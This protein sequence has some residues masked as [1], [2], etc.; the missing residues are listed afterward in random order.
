[1]LLRLLTILRD[2]HPEPAVQFEDQTV[3]LRGSGLESMLSVIAG[4]ADALDGV[5]RWVDSSPNR[6]RVDLAAATYL[7][8]IPR[9]PKII[10]I[11]LNYR[12]HAEES[13]LAIPD[14]PTVFCK[15][16][17]AATGHGH[18]VILPKNSTKPD[19]EAEFAVVIGSGGRHIA[20]EDWRK[21]VFGYTILNDVSARDFQMATS[22]WMIGKTFDTFAPIGPVI[23]TADEIE[24]PH[25]LGISLT[26]NGEVMQDSNTRNLIFRIP[27]LIAHLSSVFTLEP[28]D[29]IATGTP[30]GVGFARKP[31]RWLK[32]GDQMVTKIEGIGE[33]HNS[34]LAEV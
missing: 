14:V 26:L 30:A 16:P 12:D 31:P 22:Q 24:D 34:V 1:M 15:F 3:G 23:V 2:G 28:G 33:L 19:Y 18:P 6:A 29:I 27:Q 4:G 21:H 10:C 25:N 8:P 13:K 5:L 17:T 9:P 32:P 11:G 20:E 7:S